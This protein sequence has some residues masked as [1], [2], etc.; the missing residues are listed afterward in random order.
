MV[1]SPYDWISA[2]C[3]HLIGWPA[4]LASGIRISDVWFLNLEGEELRA[5]SYGDR[6][7][8]SRHLARGE[9]PFDPRMAAAAVEIA[10]NYQSK[11]RSHVAL[12]G[13]APLLLIIFNAFLFTAAA[14]DGDQLG[15]ALY[16]L[17]I[18]VSGVN[19]MLNPLTRPKNMA[20]SVEAARRV[21]AMRVAD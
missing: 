15:L 1:I 7:R 3:L 20:R 6:F 4:R 16:G 19:L 21:A 11:S 8:L 13:W 5:L 18:L 10:E 2:I 12:I 17:I 9:A 14:S